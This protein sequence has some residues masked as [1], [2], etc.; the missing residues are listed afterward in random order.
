M[1][2]QSGG[3]AILQAG[4]IGGT[5]AEG[6]GLAARLAAAG[7]AVLLGSRAI[8][9]ARD[10]VSSL[11]DQHGLRALE[12]ATNAEVVA[13]CDVVFLTVPFDHVT[14]AIEAH[15]DALRPGTLLVDVTVPVAFDGGTARLLEVPDGSAAEQ[16]RRLVPP[17]VRVAATLKTIP[18][19]ALGRLD[20]PLDCDEFVCGD[21]AEARERTTAILRMIPG[22]RAIDVG[23]LEAA[24][25][26]ERMTLLAIGINQRHRVRAARFRV[27]GL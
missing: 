14:A 5:G 19:S 20:A 21:S 25:I 6:R 23:G 24:R 17:Q 15:R 26:L 7:V 16:V 1:T 18:A 10:A 13:R 12:P 27:V 3:H 11:S 4:I 2:I 8:D 9:R 22:V